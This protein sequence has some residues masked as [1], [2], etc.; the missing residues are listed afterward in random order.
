MFAPT[1]LVV[2][3][4][5][6][7][8][9]L[10]G[11]RVARAEPSAD[12]AAARQLRIEERWAASES[13]ATRALGDLEHASVP[14]SIAMAEALE[15]IGVARWKLVGY[16]DGSGRAAASRS[17]EIRERRLGPDHLDV[18][19]AHALLS[20]FLQGTGRPDSALV[21]VQR[22]LE[23]RTHRLAAGDTLLA[24]TWDQLALV[25]RDR[26]DFRSALE[27]WNHAIEI[28]THANGSEHPEIA[29]L[30]AQTGVPWME[31]GDLDRARQV[32]EASL[33]MFAR[34]AGPD[35]P[36][37]WIPLN[38]L[39][40][41]ENR[42]G[43]Q[44]RNLDLL[45]EAL[46][47]VTLNY[48]G[49]AREALTLRA[50][51]S[52]ALS[53]LG[54]YDGSRTIA[55]SLLPLVESQYGPKSPRTLQIRRSLSYAALQLGD[56][57]TATRQLS[58]LESFVVANGGKPEWLLSEVLGQQAEILFLQQRNREALALSTR[59]LQIELALRPPNQENLTFLATTR[60]RIFEAMGDTAA[61]DSARR[62]LMRL[63]ERYVTGWATTHADV[64]Y[65]NAHAARRLGRLDEAWNGALESERLSR[66]RLRLNLESLPDRRAL[67]LAR[68]ENPYVEMVVDLARDGDPE[69]VRIAWDRLIRHRGAVRAEIARRTPPAGLASDSIVAGSLR[70]RLDTQR[71]LAQ[72]I[73]SSGAA[74]D[75]A[76]RVRVAA[77]RDAADDA[78]QYYARVLSDR[79]GMVDTTKVG[80]AE[81]RARLRPGQVL[82]AFC[83]LGSLVDRDRYLS[84]PD[85][86]VMAFIARGGSDGIVQAELGGS[87]EL[88]A[89]LEPWLERLAASPGPA[90]RSG[91][92]AERECRRCGRAVR[93]LTW[94]RLVPHLAGATDVYLV[95]DGVLLD[96]PWQALPE[97]STRYLVEA[98]P[99]LHLLNA[100][101]ELVED[102]AP[103][104]SGSLL[105]V[106]APDFD[107]GSTTAP[108]PA[109]A[110]VAMVVRSA[111]DPCAGAA[112]A[113]LAPLPGSG[114][115]AD[116]VGR[117]WRG[118]PNQVATVLKGAEATEASFKRMAPGRTILHIATHG[119]VA[120]DTC[121]AGTAGARGIGAA[122]PV[123]MNARTPAVAARPAAAPRA[124][125]PWLSRRVW[126]AMA[127]ANH[128]REHT[129]DENEG[130]LTAEEVL[131][132]DLSGTDW[133]VLSACHSGAAE[134]W[135]HE[136][137]NGMRRA[138]DLAGARTVIASQWAVE[139]A[140][141]REWMQA[142][143]TA[144]AAGASVAAA[145]MERASRDVLAARRKAGRST[146]P[147]YWAAFSASG[148]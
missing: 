85:A 89:A 48:G 50:N 37:R 126:I 45:Q 101:R 103:P 135:T 65:W 75:S 2:A 81:V 6:V 140:A 23:I 125:S 94:D 41:L 5:A 145:A 100:E 83:A 73:A 120:G 102:A 134:S 62:D 127:G 138:F 78:E 109:P 143:Y 40:D 53:N 3:V 19:T 144:R 112:D 54:D 132:L 67:L 123:A 76:A 14:D 71:R 59:G 16:A 129:A 97:G 11:G 148:M 98:G 99:R 33:A 34:T 77:A 32:L 146:H 131:T 68:L 142:L 133:V 66:E 52:V 95:A 139:D 55:R 104:S 4:A 20:R 7:A 42:V 64:V 44:A 147:F 17:L 46:R 58:E 86:R 69:R 63:A 84:G 43:N 51:I 116:A 110:T 56:T 49:D 35:A 1:G 60:I 10:A 28:R 9:A 137:T 118:A 79:G 117:T 136:G 22:S 27:A 115:E 114:L 87:G 90:A 57:V 38:I 122:V 124:P 130:L 91:S 105:A 80:L 26:R 70:R 39:A 93:A 13:L 141:T 119:V 30:L 82:V 88:R 96:L 25:Q 24:K 47:I 121:R 15:L 29:R 108:A 113:R 72:V 92:P 128:A 36:D 106:G 74:Q 8:L 18:A 111:P 12:L 21:H 31:L 61:L 107:S